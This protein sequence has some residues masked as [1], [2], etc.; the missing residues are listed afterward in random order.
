M[1]Y[2]FMSFSTPELSLQEMLDAAQRFGYDGIEPRMFADHGHGV[3]VTLSPAERQA[4]RVQAKES[5]IALA[6]LATSCRY[7]N[8]EMAEENVATTLR[9]IEL[10]GDLG[11]PTIRVFGGKI[12]EG[13][14]RADAID[15]VASSLSQVADQAA[16]ADVT[17]CVETHDDWCDPNHLVAVMEQVD[18][19]NIAINWDIMHPVR[20]E[21]FKMEEAF[22]IV[23]PHIRHIHFHDGAKDGTIA[24]TP[25]GEGR[26]DHEAA[27][28]LLLKTGYDGYLSG[29][30]IN[31]EDPYEV[32]LPRELATMKE[33]EKQYQG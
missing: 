1:K 22:D 12:G 18:H 20:V 27:V 5:G 24:L 31:W 13:L 30:W 14:D 23:E 17:V 11:A 28:R 10:A 8:P 4:V 15:L 7:A 26:I 2:A 19:P 25:I 6:C 9:S 21:G 32:H 33:I 3:E 29:E 16:A